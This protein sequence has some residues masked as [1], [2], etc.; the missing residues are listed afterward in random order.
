M[1]YRTTRGH[2]PANAREEQ[3]MQK[4]TTFL[5]FNNNAEEAANF[6]V[7]IFKNAKI[8]NLAR[9]GDAGP[10]PKGSVLVITF[11][12]EGQEFYALNGGPDHPLTDAI[13]LT[14]N[15][16]TQAEVDMYWEKL[17][18]AGGKPVACGWL[19]DKF[20]LSWQVTPTVLTKL[21]R[22]ENPKKVN[23]VM[24]VMMK[25]IKLDIAAMQRAYDEA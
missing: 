9:C 21:L 4:I 15:C 19:T 3:T 7:S 2:N 6:Y 22:D 25:M 17:L 18:A 12:L 14:V 20:G 1:R 24:Q 11:Q 13:S 8:V 16:E 5:W 23:A 10:G